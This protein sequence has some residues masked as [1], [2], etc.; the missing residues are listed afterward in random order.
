M[1]A[2]TGDPQTLNGTDILYRNIGSIVGQNTSN[3]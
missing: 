1:A 3:L 2:R